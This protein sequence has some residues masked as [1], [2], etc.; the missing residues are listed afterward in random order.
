[1][2]T[3]SNGH[4]AL[5]I[6]TLFDKSTHTAVRVSVLSPGL[7]HVCG[8][9]AICRVLATSRRRSRLGDRRSYMVLLKAVGRVVNAVPSFRRRSPLSAGG[10]AVFVDARMRVWRQHRQRMVPFVK[11]LKQDLCPAS[12]RCSKACLPTRFSLGVC[13]VLCFVRH[14]LQFLLRFLLRLFLSGGGHHRLHE[15]VRHH[16]AHGKDGQEREHDRRPGRAHH[17]AAVPV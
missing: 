4:L 11:T 6:R 2:T 12:A 15:A 9:L 14:V 5:C 16:Q 1:M 7:P 8:C 3:V 13:F 10:G 17:R